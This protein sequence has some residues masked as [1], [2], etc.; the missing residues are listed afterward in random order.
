MNSFHKHYQPGDLIRVNDK[1][2]NLYLVISEPFVRKGEQMIFLYHGP[3]HKTLLFA[4][5]IVMEMTEKVEDAND[6]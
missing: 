6:V 1:V 3:T 5:D 2:K 4:L